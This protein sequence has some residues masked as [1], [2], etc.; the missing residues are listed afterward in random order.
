MVDF[1]AMHEKGTAHILIVDDEAEIRL[2]LRRL[3]ER[4]GFLVSEAKDGAELF[5]VLERQPVSLITLDLRLGGEDG[6]ELA[7]R[8]RMKDNLPMVMIS[9]KGDPID[10]VV[11]LELGADDYISKPF[12]LREVLARVRAVLRRYDIGAEA[13][14][15]DRG[16]GGRKY[17]FADWMLDIS[18]RELC[19]RDGRRQELTTAEF[20]L[21]EILVAR[22]ARVL[23]RDNL[24]DLLK[25]VEWS[26]VDRTIDNLVGRLRKKIE[27]QPDAPELIKTVRGIGYVFTGEVTPE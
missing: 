10:R 15:P 17:R 27:R 23:S 19:S 14:Q 25:G 9:G 8:V 13:S 5:A 2:L 22:P 24:M 6:L 21:L 7:R 26:P 18:R 20:N 4:E 12:H 11:G 1:L 3:F 16:G